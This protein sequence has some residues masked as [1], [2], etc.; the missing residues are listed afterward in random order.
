[1]IEK[2]NDLRGAKEKSLALIVELGN[3]VEK[4]KNEDHD[5]SFKS[6]NSLLTSRY[7]C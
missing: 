5:Y 7:H 1:M 3:L 4:I 2:I 6:D